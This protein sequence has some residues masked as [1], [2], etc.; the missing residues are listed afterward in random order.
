MLSE[1]I[2]RNQHLLGDIFDFTMNASNTLWLDM[3]KDN[4]NITSEVIS[5]AQEQEKFVFGQIKEAG[6]RVG[7]GGYL[8]DRKLYQRSAIFDNEHDSRTI[9]LGIDLWIEAGTKVYTPYDGEV[10]SVKINAGVGDYGPTIILKHQL[11][12]EVFY[13][14]YGHLS[15]DSIQNLNIGDSFSTGDELCAIGNY[16]ENGH[17]AP[18][19]HF[20]L[21][22]NMEDFNDGDYPAVCTK[23]DL[24]K[25]REWCPD[26]SIMLRIS[27]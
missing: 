3:S 6:A 18:H 25:F 24:E 23:A 17:W 8:E 1:T 2:Q 10:F 21:M 26:P 4:P 11:E 27:E 22:T 20:Q 7:V 12:G 15:L 5:N 13:S 19:L 14:L 9:H 16:P